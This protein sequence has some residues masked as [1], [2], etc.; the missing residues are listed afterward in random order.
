VS[1]RPE[2]GAVSPGDQ[3]RRWSSA[4]YADP[5]TAVCPINV[6]LP[7]GAG[8]SDER[9]L[10]AGTSS[11]RTSRSRQHQRVAARHVPES[12]VRGATRSDA[13]RSGRDLEPPRTPTSLRLLDSG[14]PLRLPPPPPFICV[15]SR[16]VAARIVRSFHGAATSLPS[17]TRREV[18][19][20]RRLVERLLPSE[21]V[22]G[23]YSRRMRREDVRVAHPDQ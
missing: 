11:E 9:E 16:S 3:A 5:L 21:S 12:G 15:F 4:A 23:A 18:R 6:Q 1:H 2:G 17:R 7:S 22:V 10:G 19:N 20:T 13:D 8:A 14:S